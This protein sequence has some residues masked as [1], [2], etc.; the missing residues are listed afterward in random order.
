MGIILP[1]IVAAGI[2]DMD[3]KATSR[4]HKLNMFEIEIPIEQ[5]GTSYINDEQ[6][7]ISP[8]TLICAKPGHVRRT[9]F[10]FKCYYVHMIVPPGEL[11]SILEAMPT[12]IQTKVSFKYRYLFDEMTKYSFVNTET[13]NIKFYSLL[14][15]MIYLLHKDAKSQMNF[16]KFQ[17]NHGEMIDNIIQYILHN[18]SS[19]LS[20]KTLS[21]QV[22][23]S[24]NH[25][26]HVFKVSTGKQLQDFVE[27]QRIQKAI[28]LMITTDY[29]LTQ[30]AQECGFSSQPYF[31]HVFKK[32]MNQTPRA[33]EKQLYEK[34]NK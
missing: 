6:H 7:A 20:L 11:L 33:F 3:E 1:Q 16:S 5:G 23:L 31:N 17:K 21:E 19:D 22:H 30:I 32:R 24:P 34:Y 28:H 15:D 26:H 8:D 29:T 25:F 9:K 14:L 12:F 13:E 27:E 4:K 10:P 2:Y 18:L